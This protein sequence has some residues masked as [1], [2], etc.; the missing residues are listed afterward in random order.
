LAYKEKTNSELLRGN[1]E[2]PSLDF[3]ALGL[4][5]CQ[6][7][8]AN[9]ALKYRLRIEKGDTLAAIAEKYDTTWQSIAEMN[10][11]GANPRLAPGQIIIVEPGPGGQRSN[12]G[13]TDPAF[14]E[15]PTM[16][17]AHPSKRR[18]CSSVKVEH[19]TSLAG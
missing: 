15:T 3:F 6:T 13:I 5:H 4:F 7:P 16:E 10:S 12:L 2:K 18:A 11:L 14:P 1:N 8:K 19:N 17:A 9:Y